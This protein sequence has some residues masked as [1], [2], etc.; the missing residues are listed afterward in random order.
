MLRDYVRGLRDPASLRERQLDLQRCCNWGKYLGDSCMVYNSPVHKMFGLRILTTY[1]TDVYPDATDA[2]FT[3]CNTAFM[4]ENSQDS[5]PQ[6]NVNCGVSSLNWSY[7][8]VQPDAAKTT[9]SQSQHHHL[10]ST[11]LTKSRIL[12][13]PRLS[14]SSRN[15]HRK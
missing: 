9:A 13:S 11:K 8:R 3:V 14:H 2:S 7:Y 5:S 4:Y 6:T 12:D 15:R 10:T 1:S